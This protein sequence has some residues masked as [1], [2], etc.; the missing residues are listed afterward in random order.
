MLFVWFE[1][2]IFNDLVAANYLTFAS[3]LADF[4]SDPTIG[5]KAAATD[6]AKYPDGVHPADLVHAIMGTIA[7]TAANS[8]L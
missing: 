8:L 4:G 3:A 7:A 1:R 6:A 2:I 5:P